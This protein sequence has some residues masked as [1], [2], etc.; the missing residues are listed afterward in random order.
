MVIKLLCS[1]R[2]VY[3]VPAMGAAAGPERRVL[4]AKS[5]AD[6]IVLDLQDATPP[7]RKAEA[8]DLTSRVLCA[9]E[10]GQKTTLVR[11]NAPDTDLFHLDIE[12]VV[13]EGLAGVVCPMAN[14]PEDIRVLDGRLSQLEENAGI[15]H[16]ISIVPL[17]ET[18]SGVLQA[19]AIASSS[20]RVAGLMFGAEDF[21]VEMESSGEDQDLVLHTPRALV[22]MAARAA[23]V[24]AIDTPYLNVRD[25]EGLRR[26][27]ARGRNLGMSG[28]LVL[29]P[30]QIKVAH[31]VFTP[32][33]EAVRLAERV[34]RIRNEMLASNQAYAVVDG[35]LVSPSR[36]KQASRILTR[37]RAIREMEQRTQAARTTH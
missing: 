13:C 33:E 22:A 9:G 19:Q 7:D 32:T 35:E 21:M 25:L 29:S 36:E 10:N 14:S 34:L 20:L 15:A 2:A 12:N 3:A 31:E 4:A 30:R 24:E 23:G 18:P 6:C 17:L 27:A 5:T 8:R 1:R 26:H 11:I 28:I 37:S 16:R